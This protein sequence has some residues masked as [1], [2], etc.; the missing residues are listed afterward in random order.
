MPGAL[1]DPQVRRDFGPRPRFLRFLPSTTSWQEDSLEAKWYKNIR[2]HKETINTCKYA[3]QK[4]SSSSLNQFSSRLTVFCIRAFT[5]G[6]LS[7]LSGPTLLSFHIFWCTKIRW[8]NVRFF[9]WKKTAIDGFTGWGLKSSTP[10]AS[11]FAPHNTSD[12]CRLSNPNT[13]VQRLLHTGTLSSSS[14]SGFNSSW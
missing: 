1:Q 3:S 6:T 13:Y 9:S 14:S 5:A 8:R 7:A 2:K 10:W 4:Q 11:P 12:K